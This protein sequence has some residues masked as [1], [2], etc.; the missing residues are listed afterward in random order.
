[1]LGHQPKY[2]KMRVH[3]GKAFFPPSADELVV[4]RDKG[5]T[6]KDCRKRRLWKELYTVY[7]MQSLDLIRRW[8]CECGRTLREDN[9]TSIWI[10]QQLD[11]G[12]F[13]EAP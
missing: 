8:E 3:E 10:R 12:I 11:S 1:M 2:R 13:D 7:E 5:L 6:C 9:M 4:Q